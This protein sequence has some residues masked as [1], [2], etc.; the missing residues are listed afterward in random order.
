[1]TIEFR[2]LHKSFGAQ[3]VL[4]GLTMTIE[5]GEVFFI[6]GTSGVGKS[7]TIK[8]LVGLLQPDS[9]EILVDGKPVHGLA[10]R[11]YYPLRKRLGMV[12]QHSTLFDS[13]TV[14]DNVALP[15]RKHQRMRMSAA[16]E[17]AKERL[18]VVQMERYA[19]RWPAE[20]SSGMRKRVAIARTLTLEPQ[21]V[22]FD[23]PT[24]GL[25]PVSARRVDEMI[26]RLQT[27]DVTSVV[28]SHDLTS[29]FT[30]ADRIAFIYQGQAHIIGTPEQ[31]RAADDPI[32]Q[33][34]ISGRS[35][36]PMETP[37]F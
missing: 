11:E 12:F 28:V 15:L 14:L 20:L 8:H 10:E 21:Y 32:V 3:H 22:L 29:I 4:R 19:D 18:A 6:I 9:G 33:Q 26:K 5:R 30:I 1:M 23:E 24:T 25:D 2:D 16:R 35:D 17:A 34:F 31:L 37:G 13:L 27:L 7:V 36:G